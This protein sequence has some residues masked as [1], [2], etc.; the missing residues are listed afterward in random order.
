MPIVSVDFQFPPSAISL[1]SLRLGHRHH[2]HSPII[3][4][5]GHLISLT[6]LLTTLLPHPPPLSLLI[7]FRSGDIR[8]RRL[9][10]STPSI[11]LT[12]SLSS[13]PS[14]SSGSQSKLQR[15]SRLAIL[16]F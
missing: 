4:L 8:H 3:I 6:S 10:H 13:T 2:L 15:A 12:A 16:D 9:S 1:H 7:S 5:V 14:I 11:S